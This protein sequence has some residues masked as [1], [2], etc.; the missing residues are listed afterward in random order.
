[1]VMEMIHCYFIECEIDGQ[2]LDAGSA[3]TIEGAVSVAKVAFKFHQVP[4]RILE[5]SFD[6]PI[7]LL[8]P[9]EDM[10]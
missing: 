1:M 3:A 9:M 6:V 10:N 5:D 7:V 8:D 2:W 4:T